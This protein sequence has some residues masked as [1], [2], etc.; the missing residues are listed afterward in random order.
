MIIIRWP[1]QLTL[2]HSTPFPDAAATLTRLFAEA[3]TRLA[4]IKRDR[5]L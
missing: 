1:A 2:V 3:A 4:S 5:K